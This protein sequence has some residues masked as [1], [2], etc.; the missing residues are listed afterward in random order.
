MY[1]SMSFLQNIKSHIKH[2]I[3]I[4]PHTI[5]GSCS[6]SVIGDTRP[7]GGTTNRGV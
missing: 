5:R 6:V 1:L 3:L 4:E 7:D 2:F